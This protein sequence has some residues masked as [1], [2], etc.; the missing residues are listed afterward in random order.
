MS[1]MTEQSKH[2]SRVD[3]GRQKNADLDI[4]KP[5]RPDALES[6]NTHPVREFFSGCRSTGATGKNRSDTGEWPRFAG[7]PGVDYLRVAG[8]QCTDLTVKR[9][10]LGHIAEQVKS[11]QAGRFGIGRNP[12]AS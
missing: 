3:P 6:A 2:C 5:V 7:T 12:S 1:G 9:K 10:R 4:R 8:W 11:C